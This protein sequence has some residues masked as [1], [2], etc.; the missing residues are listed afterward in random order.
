MLNELCISY[1]KLG[2][3]DNFWTVQI[4][5]GFFISESEQNFG[6]LHTS[7]YYDSVTL[8]LMLGPTP[9]IRSPCSHHRLVLSPVSTTRVNGLS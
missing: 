1:A 2:T 7:N 6:F 4:Q 9:L 5:F 8:Q 3:D